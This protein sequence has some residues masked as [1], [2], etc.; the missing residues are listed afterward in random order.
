MIVLIRI[1]KWENL[2]KLLQ[3]LNVYQMA[4]KLD[5]RKISLPSR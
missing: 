5:D 4:I 1:Q 3:C 2:L